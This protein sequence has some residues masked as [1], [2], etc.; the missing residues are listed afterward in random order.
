MELISGAHIKYQMVY[1]LE[2]TPKCRYEIFRKEKY[3]YDYENI[4]RI[5]ARRW[6]FEILELAI[7]PDH[8]HIVV[9]VPP[10]ISASKAL[11]ILKGGSSYEFFHLHPIFRLRYPKG[12]LL[13]AG[14][15]CRTVGNVDLETTRDYV[16][17]QAQQLT[18]LSFS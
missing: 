18:L 3:R 13:S 10:S 12:H 2:W 15:F 5:I 14:K 17:S 11:Q 16:R 9:S 7:M 1:H 4:L 8:V 6:H